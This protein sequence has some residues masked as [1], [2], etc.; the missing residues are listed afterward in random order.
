MDI[1]VDLPALRILLIT[2]I[3]LS[4]LIEIKTGGTG[5]GALLGITAAAVFWGSGYISGLVNIYHIALFLGGIL[6]IIIEVF[7]PATGIFA[8]LGIVMM[9]YSIILGLGGDIG[10]VYMLAGSLII[11]V[12]LF[13][14]IVKKLPS[15]IFWQKM[16]LKDSSSSAKGYISST[17]R[18]FL[19]NKEGVV[20]TELRPAGTILID[21]SPID[22]VSEGSYISRGERVRIIKTEGNR[23]IVRQV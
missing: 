8:A 13:I 18:S 15:S 10:A 22:A 14:L 20:L 17:D 16:I 12:F 23:I 7:T 19:L 6:F 1:I 9:L 11:A 4:V 2:I 5:F 3:I 21:G